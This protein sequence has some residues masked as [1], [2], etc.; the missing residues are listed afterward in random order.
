MPCNSNIQEAQAG[1]PRV[2]SQSKIHTESKGILA[3]GDYVSK[4]TK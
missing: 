2:Q 4:I 3:V 1:G